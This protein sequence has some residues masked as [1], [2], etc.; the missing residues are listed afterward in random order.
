MRLTTKQQSGLLTAI[1]K[2]VLGDFELRLYG[3][4]LD[5]NAKGG[6]IDLLLVVDDNLVS[7]IKW[8]KHKLLVAI[9]TQIGEQK[10]D[11]SIASKKIIVADPFLSLI[12]EKSQIIGPLL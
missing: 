7:A 11:L 12:Y 3:S 6:D 9:K 4:R 8:D 2:Y 5:L 10:I 1:Q